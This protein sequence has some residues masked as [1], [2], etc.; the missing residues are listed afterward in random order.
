[1]G[2][3]VTFYSYKGGVGRSMALA[4]VASL[5]AKWG[6]K[7]LIVDWDIEAP[8]LEFFFKDYL[9]LNKTARKEGVI[10]LLSIRSDNPVD[11]IKKVDWSNYLSKI[12]IPKIENSFYLLT[13]GSVSEDYFSRVRSLDLQAYYDEK[14]G[15]FIE[16]LR[17]QW[18]QTYDFVLIDSRTGITDIGGVCTVHLPD[19]LVLFFTANEQSLKGVVEVARK[20]YQAHK[21]LPFDRLNLLTVPIPSRFDS[22]EEFQISQEWL[23]RFS[24][25]LSDLY[26][27]WLPKSISKRDFLE[28]TKLPY[29]SYFSFGEKLPVIEQGTID[30]AGLGYA[31]ETLAALVANN[32]ESVESLLENRNE[33]IRTASREL[34]R[35][36]L[37]YIHTFGEFDS[38]I[39]D[40]AYKIDWGNYFNLRTMPRQVPD[41][42]T[43]DAELL[44][45]LKQAQE[46]I[47]EHRLIRLQ[48]TGALSAGFVFGNNFK[49]VGQYRLE[50]VQST[51]TLSQIW[52]SDAEPPIGRKKPDFAR[53]FLPGNSKMSDGVVIVHAV[54]SLSLVAVAEAIGT[55]LGEADVLKQ[56]L[57]G[58]SYDSGTIRRLLIE[59]FDE[60]ELR[61][62]SY[63]LPEFSPFYRTLSKEIDKSMMISL[64]V[65]FAERRVLLQELLNAVKERNPRRY[66]IY[67]ADS[68]L[69]KVHSQKF[70]GI[71][72][73]ESEI[74]SKDRRHLEGWEAAV[75]ARSSQRLLK[76]FISEVKPKRLHL[77]M[78]VPFGL[79][80]FLGHQWNAIGKQ[81]QCYEWVGGDVVYT[82]TCLLDLS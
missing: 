50:I 22:T 77:F 15:F 75:L 53:H 80:V 24:V 54:P 26:T 30:S 76:S 29:I 16:E 60:H 67:E 46:K 79:A 61:E 68:R 63:D 19:I 56:F 47:G 64:L 7:V 58:T 33:F 48:S 8:G 1:M 21:K 74:A 36:S 55:Y 13:A 2:E 5:L 31:Y 3:I 17:N 4:N 11:A 34:S 38:S 51:S 14:G 57:A 69:I 49:G 42:A 44:P 27:D 78:A 59:S 52:F 45:Q 62:L 40:S 81:V 39:P 32:L 70:R 41:P 35:E 28:V 20:A 23:D 6:Y 72:F 12:L 43:W 25:E 82:P 65:D 10:D 9:D 37:V 73:L 66:A 18:K 71:L